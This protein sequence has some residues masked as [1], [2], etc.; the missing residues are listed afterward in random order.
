MHF[1]Y[2]LSNLQL[3]SS[4]I[5]GSQRRHVLLKKKL[6]WYLEVKQLASFTKSRNGISVLQIIAEWDEMDRSGI[7]K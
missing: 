1:N 4:S 7:L 2:F 6:V 3:S 5:S